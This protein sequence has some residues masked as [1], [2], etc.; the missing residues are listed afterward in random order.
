MRRE[1]ESHWPLWTLGAVTAILGISLYSVKRRRRAHLDMSDS[2][3]S[4]E[5]FVPSIVGVT[6]GTMTEGNALE[7]VQNGAFFE[8]LNRDL[9]GAKHSINFETFLCKKGE[10]SHRIAEILARKAREGVEVRMLLDGTGGK[11][12]GKDDLDLMYDA[13]VDV[14]KYHP[15]QISNLGVITNRDH[16]KLVVVDGRIGYIGGHCLVDNWM[17]DAQDKDHYRDISARVQGPVVQQIQSAFIENWLETAGDVPGGQHH[18]PKLE[19]KGDAGAHVVWVSPHGSPSTVKLLHYMAIKGAKKRITIQNPYFLPEEDMRNALIEA[20]KRGV[21]VRV[22]I[23]DAKIS[24]APVVQHASHHRYGAFLAGGV[25]IFDYQRTLL[26]QKVMTIDGVWS[27]IGSTNWDS[28]SFEY[29]DEATMGVYDED[30]ARQ[31]EEVFERDLEHAVE[32]KADEWE[33]RELSHKLI[34]FAAYMLRDQL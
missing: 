21:E 18:F 14:R 23:P 2:G 34:D 26:H 31:L 29:N 7:L 1:G 4:F 11:D 8:S 24:D 9:E 30:V 27:A 25:R 3:G 13:G 15:F 19:P 17:G 33:H 32:R 28:R 6:Q 10:V 12:I 22:M 5:D 20:A 16:R